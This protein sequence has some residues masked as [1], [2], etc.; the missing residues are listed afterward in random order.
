MRQ[1]TH[2]P[3]SSAVE[4][5]RPPPPSCFLLGCLLHL[6]LGWGEVRTARSTVSEVASPHPPASCLLRPAASC[7]PSPYDPTH[8][9]PLTLLHHRLS[10][11]DPTTSF[12]PSFSHL[13]TSHH[14]SFRLLVPSLPFCLRYHHPQPS[15]R[16]F[17]LLELA[18]P[19]SL[20][21]C[22]SPSSPPPTHG[23]SPPPP[24]PS[25]VLQAEAFHQ[26]SSFN[27]CLHRIPSIQPVVERKK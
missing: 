16:R 27:A 17:F 8:P 20:R 5:L 4:Q 6:G 2:P 13:I 21:H 15:I 22:L 10:L 26:T 19:H 14:L 23:Y 24:P 9:S 25:T 1:P 7:S 18:P 3:D 12:L 11:F